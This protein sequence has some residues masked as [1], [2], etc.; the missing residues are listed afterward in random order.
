ML[1]E[2]KKSN[3]RADRARAKSITSDT[4]D[5]LDWASVFVYKC[6]RIFLARCIRIPN[7]SSTHFITSLHCT[8]TSTH[9]VRAFQDLYSIWYHGSRSSGSSY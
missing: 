4:A 9:D 7:I 1:E 8:R 3:A 2:N 5:T 6:I